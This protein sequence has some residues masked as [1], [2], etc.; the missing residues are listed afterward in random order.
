MRPF[1]QRPDRGVSLGTGL[2][3]WR[4]MW[5]RARNCRY[6]PT[7]PSGRLWTLLGRAFFN[8][9]DYPAAAA[10]AADDLTA[11]RIFPYH[12]DSGTSK[13]CLHQGGAIEEADLGE[14]GA[15]SE[16]YAITTGASS[17]GQPSAWKDLL[18]YPTGPTGLLLRAAAGWAKAG[19]PIPQDQFNI[20][21]EATGPPWCEARTF[22]TQYTFR[23]YDENYD[24]ESVHG[25]IAQRGVFGAD[26]ISAV[27]LR[28]INGITA[29]DGF[30]THVRIYS[31]LVDEPPGVF[32][33]IDGLD[34]G[35]PIADFVPGYEFLH[36]TEVNL[37]SNID[38]QI[39]GTVRA[40]G[41]EGTPTWAEH[42]GPPPLGTGA[43]MFQN[44]LVIWGVPGREQDLLYSALGYPWAFPMDFGSGTLTAVPDPTYQY[45]LTMASDQPDVVIVCRLAGPYLLAFGKFAIFRISVLP[46]FAFPGFDQVVQDLLSSE[47][48]C[49][50]ELAAATFGI[51]GS[52]QRD[53]PLQCVYVSR[54]HG[55]MLTNGVY[56]IPIVQHLA[57]DQIADPA[58]MDQTVCLNK[59]DTQ[60]VWIYYTPMGETR[61]TQALIISYAEIERSGLRITWPVDVK[62]DHATYGSGNDGVDRMYQMVADDRRVYV[63]DSGTTDAQKNYNPGGD[64]RIEVESGREFTR[65]TTGKVRVTRAM[66]NGQSG[67]ERILT[68]KFLSLDGREEYTV[69][70]MP[71]VGPGETSDA[72]MVNQAGQCVR[73]RLEFTGPTGST[74][75]EDDAACALCIDSVE[76]EVDAAGRQLQT[77]T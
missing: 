5:L 63:Q 24:T 21:V 54:E 66:V 7:D 12:S 75:D 4:K 11:K 72:A 20:D 56:D 26:T 48:G 33:R 8:S 43:I 51:A 36:V 60:E 39:N 10:P 19:H 67:P 68:A 53:E 30:G 52:D 16:A 25:W 6:L 47:H 61:N 58:Y 57:W 55:P 49:V 2:R 64:V 13:L 1:V 35:I 73:C 23:I 70:D 50:G 71:R 40:D 15:F 46:S 69:Q 32:Y 34:E 41:E 65:G 28:F 29:P 62:C 59:P 74:Y 31:T 14:T 45:F 76:Y 37:D 42:G 18:F 77:R 22:N 17:A 3:A 38:A 27:V 44:R 9:A